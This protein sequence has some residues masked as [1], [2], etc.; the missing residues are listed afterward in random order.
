MRLPED[1]NSNSFSIIILSF[2]TPHLKSYMEAS[3]SHCLHTGEA[4][5]LHQFL[6]FVA[7]AEHVFDCL[8]VVAAHAMRLGTKFF[9]N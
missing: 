7:V 2:P 9:A 4:G 5:H 1:I 3:L 8:E 6:L